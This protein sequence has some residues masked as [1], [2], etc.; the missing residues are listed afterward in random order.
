M[1][2]N[3]ITNFLETSFLHSLSLP[4]M[5]FWGV[6]VKSGE[7]LK[8]DPGN[9]TI[10]HLSMA[11]LGEVNKDKGGEPVLLYVK[12]DD[13]KL[14]LGTLSSDKFP[15]IS[16][17]LIFE[18]EFELSHNWKHG[19][20]FFNGYRA[21]AQVGSYPVENDDN[22]DDA[23]F[24]KY[25]QVSTANGESEADVKNSVKPDANE[26][27]QNEKIA[28]PIK[29]EKAKE[30][31]DSSDESDEDSSENEPMANGEI[32]SSEDEDDSNEEEDDEDESDD[33]DEET[34]KKAEPSNKRALDSSKKT[35]VPEKKAK[36]IT[37]QKTG[38]KSGSGHVDTPH[39][40]KQAGKAAVSNNQPAKQHTPKSG[41]EYSCKPC[42]RSFKTEDALGSH[43]KAKHSAK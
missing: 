21:E 22:E 30:K 35:P 28:D 5:E 29:N 39:P 41:G 15:Q 40:S 17:D 37:P 42:N 2:W 38:G 31:E 4:K 16:Y 10:I 20:V 25:I 26:A 3:Q 23:D 27:K 36:F 9:D 32:R 7:S 19:S 13:Q 14:V 43:N 24:R 12:F 1:Q 6:E 18:K 8:V 33:E 11:C 34:P